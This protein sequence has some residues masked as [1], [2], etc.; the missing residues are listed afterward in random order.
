MAP[1]FR[2]GRYGPGSLAGDERIIGRIAQGAE[3]RRS[4]GVRVPRERAAERP[5]ADS[6]LG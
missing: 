5:A 1:E 6:A 2:N 4:T 3:R